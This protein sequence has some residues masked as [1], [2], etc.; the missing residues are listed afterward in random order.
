M[1]RKP[2]RHSSSAN[3]Y[4]RCAQFG[5]TIIL[6]H[7][8]LCRANK[9]NEKR[10]ISCV[11]IFP[12]FYFPSSFTM[13]EWVELNLH[14]NNNNQII[15][16]N[17]N[18]ADITKRKN[19]KKMNEWMIKEWCEKS[20]KMMS[21]QTLEFY[22]MNPMMSDNCKTSIY[23]NS[24]YYT[25]NFPLDGCARRTLYSQWVILIMHRSPM[26]WPPTL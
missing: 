22:R 4:T 1:K 10:N 26:R 20:R 18:D 6:S 7:R 16:R 9:R 17:K 24:P 13:W 2:Q 23:L 3:S 14:N 15:G 5:R 11:Y 21:G 12:S 25:V 8:D 19:K